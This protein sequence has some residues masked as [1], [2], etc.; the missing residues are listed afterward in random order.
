MIDG[1]PEQL[2]ALLLGGVVLELSVE[3]AKPFE[4][5]VSGAL[6]GFGAA[7]WFLG[8]PLVAAL[9][10]SSTACAMSFCQRAGWVGGSGNTAGGGRLTVATSSLQRP[11]S[12]LP[13]RSSRSVAHVRAHISIKRQSGI[14]L[15]W[16]FRSR[17]GWCGLRRRRSWFRWWGGYGLQRGCVDGGGL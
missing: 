13:L 6:R 16:W 10:D 1:S 3:E 5:A 11:P 14:Q 2:L 4:L 15:F 12:G 7:G 8:Q 17:W 9:G